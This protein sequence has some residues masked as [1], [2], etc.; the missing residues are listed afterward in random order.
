MLELKNV[1]KFYYSKG[2]IAS[3]FSRVNLKLSLGEFVVITGESGS[4]KSTL[5]NVLSGLDTYEEGE[6]YINGQE[7]SHYNEADFE[8]YRRRYV[9]NIFQNFNLVNSYTVYQNV[10]LAL[11][12]SGE[13]RKDVRGKVM[14][15]I[16]RVGL[17]DFAGTKCAKLSGGQ[18]QRVAIARAL[19][20][21][22]PI[23]TADEPT[24][25]L[26]SKAAGEVM[27]LLS[28]I[29]KDKLV[30]VVTHNLEQVE[31][32]ATRLI[33]MHDGKILEDKT[34]Q[35][36]QAEE[37]ES[38]HQYRDITPGGRLRLGTRNAFN[39]PAK[40]LLILAVF[41]FVVSSVAGTY[42]SFEKMAYEESLYGYSDF[43]TDTS[44]KR[45]VINKQDRS[46]IAEDEFAAVEALN[47]VERVVRDDTLVDYATPV[48]DVDYMFFFYGSFQDVKYF[49][50]ELAA[51]RLPQNEGEIVLVGTENDYALS[52]ENLP[53]ILERD[54]Y[55]ESYDDEGNLITEDP[56]RIVGIAVL[57]AE[58]AGSGDIL[59]AGEEV[60]DKLRYKVAMENN[61]VRTLFAGQYYQSEP[62]DPL[63]RVIPCAAVP[64]GEAY[65]SSMLADYTQDGL[66]V[67]K[68]LEIS[69][70]SIYNHDQLSLTV[71]RTYNKFNFRELTG[72]E[73]NQAAEGAIYVNDREYEALVDKGFFQSSVYVKDV[74]KLDETA[75]ALEKLGFTAL[76][77]RE[78]LNRDGGELVQMINLLKTFML[79]LL[80]ITLFFISYFI[81]RIVLK[82]RNAYYTTL[83][84][85]GA[86]RRISKQLL[87]IELMLT[88]TLAYA[89]FMAVMLLASAG[90]ITQESLCEMATYLGAGDYA[91]IYAIILAMSYLISHRF[92]RKLFR[93][94]V[95]NTY[96]EEA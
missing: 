85:L 27:K 10:E 90:V 72:L 39:I 88:A 36:P 37:N 67:G 96:R 48:T 8:E 18:K 83:R 14:E 6:M 86:S 82:S 28:E 62:Y 12:L 53:L 45:I 54:F 3:G 16:R 56:L 31:K 13:K 15:I 5:L 58:E 87:D 42:S 47:N 60:L 24:G 35:K 44:D 29:A 2:V 26:D 76:P 32:Y 11:L 69:A 7:T 33:K 51:G 66:A 49:R 20:K 93:D 22:T 95:M 4:G 43:F 9:G 38:G 61:N 65:V 91:L 19:A 34:L 80:V 46:V 55:L 84:M 63:F 57:P 94:S 75:A 1:S 25:N 30:I 41:L 17:A 77:M 79:A 92:A 68:E 71:S 78:A 81:I 73:Y 74:H 50:G 64:A 89:L 21:D 70:D 52:E 40:F 59:Y 23:I